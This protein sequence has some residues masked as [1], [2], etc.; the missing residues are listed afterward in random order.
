MFE[1]S[2]G[3][4]L[5]SDFLSEIPA[6]VGLAVESLR[7]GS[8][9]ADIAEKQHFHFEITA[10]VRDAQHIADANFA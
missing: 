10:I 4:A 2:H 3:F 8:W 5:G 7:D 9:T 1:L 6:G